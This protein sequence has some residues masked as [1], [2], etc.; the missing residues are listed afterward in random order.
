MLSHK[1]DGWVNQYG[2][3][4]VVVTVFQNGED[5]IY[6]PQNQYTLIDLNVP[7]INRYK[8]SDL[9]S[10][11]NKLK[12][13]FNT[14]QPVLVISTLTGIPSLVLPLVKPSF[15]KVMEVHSSGALS[16][17]D[18]WRYKWWFLKIYKYIVLLN[19]D[20]KQ[21]YKTDNL[22]VI[23]NFVSGQISDRSYDGREKRIVTA[24]RLHPE[25][26]FDHLLKAWQIICHQFPEWR[27]EIYGNG[28]ESL[29]KKLQRFILD[30]AME[31]T[32]IY[33]ATSEL[34]HILETSSLF[35][36]T[37]ETECF[38]MVLLECKKALLPAISYDSPNGPRNIIDG[39]GE[40]V[41]HND[42]N[43]FALR[44]AALIQDE[45]RRITYA[46]K[47]LLNLENFSEKNIMKKWN[48]LL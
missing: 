10:F 16:V 47:A 12:R 11:R 24:G 5:V 26:Q 36:L 48:S 1:I 28:D 23:P 27:L 22:T 42:I 39:D 34:D 32:F 35:A 46:T 19:E 37:S 3:H 25:K 43:E 21:Y 2:Y 4:V 40:L 9:W 8:W 33:P 6:P 18:S 45:K 17:N 7:G 30:H 38:P 14:W 29:R 44:L 31:R 13:I 20:E 15:P 41:R